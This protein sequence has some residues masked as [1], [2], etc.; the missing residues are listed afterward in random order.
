MQQKREKRLRPGEILFRQRLDLLPEAAEDNGE[1]HH[2]DHAERIDDAAGAAHEKSGAARLLVDVLQPAD[3]R[4]KAHRR[5][6]YR[7][8]DG[9]AQNTNAAAVHIRNDNADKL[10]HGVG[11]H[12]R[13]CCEQLLL[14]DGRIR[15]KRH[16]HNDDGD[17][18][19]KKPERRGGGNGCDLSSAHVLGNVLKVFDQFTNLFH[20]A[21]Y[22]L[23]PA[24]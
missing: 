24:A 6:P 11:Q 23:F 13:E 5:R 19:Q 1:E 3:E 7:R 2:E 16:A 20:S 21:D 4:G 8:H 14:G 17:D 22:I 18:R 12:G 15:Q 10:I 9:N